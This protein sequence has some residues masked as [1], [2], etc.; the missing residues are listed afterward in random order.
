LGVPQL[1]APRL[2]NRL[3]GVTG[4]DRSRTLIRIVGLREVGSGIGILSHPRPAGFLFTRVAGDAMDLLLLLAALRAKGTARHRV[5]AAT[6]AVTSIAIVDV[7]ASAKAS[8]SSH[9]AAADSAV[10]SAQDTANYPP[11]KLHQYGHR[12][13]NLP[14]LAAAFRD[15]AGLRR[16]RAFHPRG[17]VLAGEWTTGQASRLPLDAGIRP[18]IARIS[19]GAGTPGGA[20]DILGLAVRIP[21][22]NGL[23]QSWD[24][25]LSS[26]GSGALSR[27]V[28]IPAR[29]WDKVR[30]GSIVPYRYGN[31]QML[32]LA[33]PEGSQPSEPA[34]LELLERWVRNRPLRFVIHTGVYG[35]GWQEAATLTLHTVLPDAEADRLAFDPMRNCPPTLR[36]SPRWFSRMRERA[37]QGSRAGRASPVF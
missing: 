8:R 30:Y 36:M 26:S 18:V 1:L 32:L 6:A 3:I 24:I 28:P 2:I 7:I 17:L 9:Q 14:L 29:R 37:Y 15:V 16:A 11:A 27:M 31:R 23:T 35:D 33:I 19:K 22:E 4:T 10:R 21:T 34:S 12:F 20:P 5:A 25:A 13:E